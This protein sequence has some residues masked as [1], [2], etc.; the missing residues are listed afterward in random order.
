MIRA[1]NEHT[2]VPSARMQRKLDWHYGSHN[3]FLPVNKHMKFD[4][5]YEKPSVT[6]NWL[7][8]QE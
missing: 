6:N 1:L 4:E 5:I 3:G 8:I 2:M 7:V